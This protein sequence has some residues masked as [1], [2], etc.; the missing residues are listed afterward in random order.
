MFLQNLT[1]GRRNSKTFNSKLCSKIFAYQFV[2]FAL[3]VLYYKGLFQAAEKYDH[4]KI[5]S[6]PRPSG[7]SLAEFDGSN[8]AIEYD[9]TLN[10][11][12]IQ[13]VPYPT[14]V[15]KSWKIEGTFELIQEQPV[16]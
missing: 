15:A 3:N 13:W 11:V 5:N 14:N 6:G 8:E 4:L 7:F 2:S 9:W 10:L 16:E 12:T 1:T